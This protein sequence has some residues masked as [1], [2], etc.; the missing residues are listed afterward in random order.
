M[1]LNAAAQQKLRKVSGDTL[2]QNVRVDPGTGSSYEV[3]YSVQEPSDSVGDVGAEAV[4]LEDFL[5]ETHT[6]NASMTAVKVE[7]EAVYEAPENPNPSR[8][9]YGVGEKVKLKHRPQSIGFEWGIGTEDLWSILEDGDG[10]DKILKLHY[11]GGTITEVVG[12]C[13]GERYRPSIAVFEPESV[14]C[15][16]HAW[17]G[18]CSPLGEA[19]GFGMD[20]WLSIGPMHLSFQGIDVAEIPC[21]TAIPPT[22]YYATTNFNGVLTHNLDAGA[23]YWH[24]VSAGNYWCVDN[25]QSNIR[26][27][28]WSNGQLQ[29]N[30]P[31]QWYQRLE[32]TESWSRGFVHADGRLIGGSIGAYKQVFDITADG[33][34]TVTKHQHWIDRNTN[35]VIRLDGEMVHD[36]EHR[37]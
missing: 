3:V 25:A 14:L 17:D 6:G 16:N 13:C 34:V 4:F 28:Q 29:W 5:D 31:I 23:G 27:Q 2:P 36:G 32:S 37:R 18:L 19:G 30:I 15:L 24:H 9:I 35:D 7:M 8:H 21:E 22:G 1:T 11:L 20:L 10:C 33:T 26:R 12:T